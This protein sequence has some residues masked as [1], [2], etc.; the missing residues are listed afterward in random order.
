MIPQS[1]LIRLKAVSYDLFEGACHLATADAKAES[2]Y[3]ADSE[4]RT[5][6]YELEKEVQHG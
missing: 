4:L 5:I 6:I 2:I 3:R 1:I